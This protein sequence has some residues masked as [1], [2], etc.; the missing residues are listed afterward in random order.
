MQGK[1]AET[2]MGKR[3]DVCADESGLDSH[4]GAASPQ[5]TAWSKEGEWFDVCP[6]VFQSIL[7]G[8]LRYS[9]WASLAFQHQFW[10]L[11]IL[12]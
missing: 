9:C 10:L 8:A 12:S 2:K 1:E 11:L 4:P 6:G 7:L 3:A 5:A